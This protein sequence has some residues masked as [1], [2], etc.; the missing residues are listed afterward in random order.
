M[1]PSNLGGGIAAAP[2]PTNRPRAR[3]GSRR[4][5]CDAPAPPTADRESRSP[6]VSGTRRDVNRA[7]GGSGVRNVVRVAG[8]GLL[9]YGGG[10]DLLVD[11]AGPE[12]SR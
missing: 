4:S 3:A 5:V 8:D 11:D 9:V 10:Q 2:Y 12:R 6:S 7:I 1:H